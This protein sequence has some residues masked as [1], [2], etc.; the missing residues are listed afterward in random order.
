MNKEQLVERASDLHL[1]GY[2]CAQAVACALVEAMGL[3]V[4]VP[5]LF[6]ATEG[7]GLGMGG[8]MGT[9]GAVSGACVAAGLATSTRNL[10]AP[11]SKAATYT[12]CRELMDRYQEAVGSVTCGVIKGRTGGPVL[13]ACHECVRT[14]AAV[15][16]DVLLGAGA[17]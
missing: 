15:A 4:D 6:A 10:E 7:L 1:A 3:D 17:E 9:C 2:N 11:N 12:V 16:Y 14:G 8:M 13:M 5:Q